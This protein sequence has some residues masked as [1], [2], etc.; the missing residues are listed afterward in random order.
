MATFTLAII[1][2]VIITLGIVKP[3]NKSVEFARA[4]ARGD[5]DAKIDIDQNVGDQE[6]FEPYR[7]FAKQ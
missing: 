4:V 3:M 6:A 2:A 7:C 1:I 5:L